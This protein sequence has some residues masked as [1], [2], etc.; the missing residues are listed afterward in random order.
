MYVWQLPIPA[1]NEREELHARL[2][3][4]GAKAAKFSAALSLPRTRFE[5]QR[6]YLR[7]SLSKNELGEEID[8]GVKELLKE[9]S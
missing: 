9:S 3:E 4:L 2:A 6:R 7:E 5:K 1:F 8:R